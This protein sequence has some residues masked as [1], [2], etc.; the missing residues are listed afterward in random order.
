[1]RE[2]LRQPSTAVGTVF[3]GALAPRTPPVAVV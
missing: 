1:M 3:G 2:R